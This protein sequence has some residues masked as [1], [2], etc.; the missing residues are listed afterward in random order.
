MILRERGKCYGEKIK[1][2]IVLRI[3]FPSTLETELSQGHMQP[4][5]GLHQFSCKCPLLTDAM[6]MGEV[7]PRARLQGFSAGSTLSSCY[8][9]IKNH[10]SICF[11]LLDGILPRCDVNGSNRSGLYS[12]SNTVILLLRSRMVSPVLSSGN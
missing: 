1:N 12:L 2:T 5:S 9:N 7:I 4:S 3:R 11:S 10:Q 8:W 6:G